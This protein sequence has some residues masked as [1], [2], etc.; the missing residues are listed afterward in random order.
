[1][2]QAFTRR[3]TQPLMGRYV[4]LRKRMTCCYISLFCSSGPCCCDSRIHATGT[5]GQRDL[6]GSLQKQRF[7]DPPLPPSFQS[8]PSPVRGGRHSSFIPRRC[9]PQLRLASYRAALEGRREFFQA[10][11]LSFLLYSQIV[12][13]QLNPEENR[14]DWAT[15]NWL[16]EER[17]TK[18]TVPVNRKN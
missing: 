8:P 4:F 10:K 5:H 9:G 1:M 3:L 7:A 15:K 16:L 12:S 11:I 17:H 13:T 2:E 6:D 14:T 18:L